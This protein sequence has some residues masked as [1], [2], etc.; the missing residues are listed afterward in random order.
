MKRGLE[1]NLADI[2]IFV[3]NSGK[4]IGNEMVPVKKPIISEGVLNI[5]H[6]WLIRTKEGIN[7]GRHRGI[8]LLLFGRRGS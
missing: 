1:I 6:E 3:L 7:G 5:K 8:A 2:I 4:N